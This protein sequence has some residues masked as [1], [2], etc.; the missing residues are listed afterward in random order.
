M[1]GIDHD[2]K[3]IRNRYLQICD[4]FTLVN[5]TPSERREMVAADYRKAQDIGI[6]PEVLKDDIKK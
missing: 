2:E 3:L 1:Q 4:K 6:T 5:V